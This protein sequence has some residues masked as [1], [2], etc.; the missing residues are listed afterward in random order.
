[1]R[2]LF[3]IGFVVM[4]AAQWYA[5]LSMVYDSEKIVDEGVEYRFRTAPVDPSDPFR[6]KYI[7]LNFEAETYVPADTNELHFNYDQQVYATITPDSLGFA[8]ITRLAAE[9]PDADI[10]YMTVTF[11]YGSKGYEYASG[12][13]ISPSINLEFPFQ[14][15]YVEESKASEAEK[16]YWEAARNDSTL[17]CY[18][19]VR[20][21]KGN[22]TLVDVMVND[23]PIID[24]VREIN[25]SQD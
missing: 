3:I 1:M 19:M 13:R 21:L 16:F 6:G 14:R 22:S 17:V 2:Y 25:A 23:R 7:T 9:P 18:A 15:L 10:D 5:P 8:K 20:I 11:R 4:V 12:E 24:I